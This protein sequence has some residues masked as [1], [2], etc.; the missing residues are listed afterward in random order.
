MPAPAVLCDQT[1]QMCDRQPMAFL[2]LVPCLNGTAEVRVLHRFMRY[3]EL[4]GEVATGFHD[5]VL[6][7]LGDVRPNQIPVVDVQANILHLATTGVRVPTAA[8]MDDVVATSMDDVV[9]TW[10]EGPTFLGPFADGDPNPEVVRPRNIQLL[11]SRYAAMLVHRERVSPRMAYRELAGAFQADGN[12]EACGDVIA[13]LRVVCTC[14]GE[15][16]LKP[17]PIVIV[18]IPLCICRKSCTTT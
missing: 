13:W 10:A 9:A 5:H 8:T 2:C 16:A 14:Q 17:T 7:L 15:G 4:P 1:V 6:D 18:M 12:M 3:L 11:P